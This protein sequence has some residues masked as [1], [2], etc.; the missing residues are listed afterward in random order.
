MKHLGDSMDQEGGNL[1]LKDNFFVKNHL[2]K[3]E[4]NVIKKNF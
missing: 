3:G 4:Q 1:F 2:S